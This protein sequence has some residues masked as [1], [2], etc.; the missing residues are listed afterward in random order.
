MISH[1]RV[2]YIDDSPFD[3]DLVKD[4]LSSSDKQFVITDISN[5]KQ[6]EAVLE[7]EEFDCVLSD[8][9]I[10]GYTGLDVF[11]V[12]I[13]LSPHTPVIILTGTGSEECA[14]EAMKR[15][16]ADYILK[17]P[18]HIMRLP[19]SLSAAV[20]AARSASQKRESE[21]YL[22]I[23]ASVFRASREAVMVT[24]PQACLT[25]VNPSFSSITGY[26]FEEVQGRN[27]SLLRSGR[28][29]SEFYRSMWASIT[30]DG[31]WQGE[32]WN[33][34]KDGSEW[35][36][37]LSIT[38]VRDDEGVVRHYAGVLT[39]MTERWQASER[40]KFLA[41]HDP[42][43]GLSNRTH[44]EEQVKRYIE[45]S[46]STAKVSGLLF[47]DIDNFKSINGRFGHL[48]GDELLKAV[49][50]R[51]KSCAKYSNAICRLGGDEFMIFIPDS[52][53]IQSVG[54]E[55][56]RILHKL[57]VPYEIHDQ[58]LQASVSIGIAMYPEDGR[59]ME[60]LIRNVD[61]AMSHAKESGRNTFRF[62]EH[63]MKSGAEKYLYLRHSLIQALERNEFILHYQ[64]QI[65]LSTGNLVGVEALIRWDHPDQGMVLPGHFITL[66]EDNG[67]IVPIGEWVIREAC[68][69]MVAWKRDGM[70]K[71]VVAVNLSALQFRRGDLEL[72][73][74]TAL[75]DTGLEP[76]CLELE[77]TES[78]LIKNV[79]TVLATVRRLKTLGLTLSIDDFGTGYSS[80]AYLKRFKVD[81]LKID[82]SFVRD[83]T[84]DPE[85]ETIVR[86][87]VQMAH[88][89][90]LR[91]IAEGVED[92]ETMEHL[93]RLN[94]DEIQGY[95]IARPMPPDEF[96]RFVIARSFH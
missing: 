80:L 18:K 39:D 57:A 93:R 11:D 85:D 94:C 25:I 23:A 33:K 68:R 58:I 52:A 87:I 79:D 74:T 24:D 77:L 15:G 26:S 51:L 19:Y 54:D 36:S 47:V 8:L 41:Y 73:V 22:R 55:A 43:T 78:I 82:Q 13:R 67:L 34:R 75:N 10:L 32:I 65:D 3:R 37:W 14:V 92:A 40:M 21:A 30:R 4:A 90:N 81:K 60:T 69:Q 16:V 17:T 45:H 46:G 48:F 9:N 28:H 27:P 53:D 71:M 5:R 63:N 66:A 76:S 61:T 91:T 84:S 6:L 86:T 7:G 88:S 95:H 83:L 50:E 72:M 64:P 29:S 31:Y 62:F 49:A 1:I 70:P 44:F 20:E 89:L 59:D 56:A 38:A 35:P 2:L 42:L 96:E 12:V